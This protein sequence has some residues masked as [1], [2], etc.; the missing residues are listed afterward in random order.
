MLAKKS[1][2]TKGIVEKVFKV[3]KFINS[4]LFSFKFTKKNDASKP[5][6]SV[7][8]PKNIAKKA[9][10]RNFLRRLGY[11]SLKS[12]INKAPLGIEGVLIFKKSTKSK[13]DVEREI[14]RIFNKIY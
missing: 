5:R 7:L 1:R 8:A 4:E 11:N 9:V 12:L 2:V 3:G 14:E 13:T 6:I 10:D